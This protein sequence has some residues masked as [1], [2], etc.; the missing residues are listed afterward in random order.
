MFQKERP[1]ALPHL[2]MPGETVSGAIKKLNL[3]DVT[4]E[5]MGELLEQFKKINPD[6]PRPGMRVLI[7]VLTRHQGEVFKD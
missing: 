7:P 5:E 4:K 2:F 6:L 1:K 3:Y